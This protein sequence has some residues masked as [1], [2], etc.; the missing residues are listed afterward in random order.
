[1]I[2]VRW[3]MMLL[4]VEAL[5]RLREFCRHQ[6]RS[7]MLLKLLVPLVLLLLLP[8]VHLLLELRTR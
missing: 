7:L 1:M 5:F 6:V 3:K 8:L 4:R 2:R